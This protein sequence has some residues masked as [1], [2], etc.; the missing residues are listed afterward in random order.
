MRPLAE[1]EPLKRGYD[2]DENAIRF[3]NYFHVLRELVHLSCGWLPLVPEF[4]RKL[5]LGE[6]IHDDARAI[7][8][9]KRRLYELRHP[10]EYPGAPGPELLRLLDRL[11]GADAPGP[12]IAHAY[13]EAKTALRR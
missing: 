6:H 10:S 1:P 12:Y 7:S 3:S 11:A 4:E 13:G 2:V 8:R 9:I 5:R